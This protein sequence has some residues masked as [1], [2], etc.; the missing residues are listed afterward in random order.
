M[1]FLKKWPL[2]GAKH[3]VLTIFGI[4]AALASRD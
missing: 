4:L 1:R 3:G 2:N